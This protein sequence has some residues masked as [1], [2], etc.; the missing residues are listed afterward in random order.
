MV[1]PNFTVRS[2]PSSEIVSEIMGPFD[3]ANR[4]TGT[5]NATSN[6]AFI[7]GSSKHGKACLASVLSNWVVAIFRSSPDSSVKVEM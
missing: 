5:V 3:A 1:V 6:D 2:A 7:A 4:S